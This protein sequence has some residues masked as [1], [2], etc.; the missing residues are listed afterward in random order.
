MIFSLDGGLHLEQAT[1]VL[2]AGK[3]LFIG[4]PM[5]ASA[6]DVGKIFQIEAETLEIFALLQAAETSRAQNGAIVRLP[7]LAA[8]ANGATGK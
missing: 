4:R 6:E 8:E 5:A 7:D 3:R 2:R 1:A